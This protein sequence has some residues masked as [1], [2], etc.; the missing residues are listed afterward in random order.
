MN[1]NPNVFSKWL[2]VVII[3][4]TLIGIASC[5]YVIPECGSIFRMRYPEFAGWVYP[6]MILLYACSIPCFA[7]MV[8]CWK[9]AA[10]INNDMSFSSENAK[11]FKLFSYL[12]AGDT[13]AF[14]AGCVVFLAAG[15]NHPGMLIIEMLIVF[16]GIAVFVCTAALSYLVAQ[17]A[18]LQEESDLTI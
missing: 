1:M 11:L 17:A 15:I 4:T 2:K 10:N 7:A 6:W 12:A 14:F 16:V 5:V 8:I 9:I 13:A 18:N 3:G